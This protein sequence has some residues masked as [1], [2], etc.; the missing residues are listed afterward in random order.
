MKPYTVFF[1]AGL[2]ILSSVSLYCA[3]Q[4]VAFVG[5]KV[6]LK[7]EV[8]Q[9][10]KADGVEFNESLNRVISEK[11]LLSEAENIG[12]E[13]QEEE[14]LNEIADVKKKF[15]DEAAFQKQLKE[16]NLT[17][18]AFKEKIKERLLAKKLIGQKVMNEISISTS[19]LMKVY[20]EEKGKYGIEYYLEGKDFDTN[21]KAEQ[22]YLSWNDK[23]ESEMEKIG[24]IRE[25]ELLP[26]VYVEIKDLKEG[27]I[28]KSVL[29]SK[30]W[31]IFLVKE[32]KKEEMSEERL[33]GIVKNQVFNRKFNEKISQLIEE[34]KKKIPVKIL[35]EG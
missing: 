28:S 14:I 16:D 31:H 21:E 4:T 13:I 34:I 15:P 7:S 9:G 5:N 1:I 29:V 27:Q 23:S 24:W 18:R 2:F 32:I 6:I 12:I 11:L 3:D 26:H 30:K 33:F 20:K 17:H 8:E 25:N 35:N 22:F 19:E 10:M